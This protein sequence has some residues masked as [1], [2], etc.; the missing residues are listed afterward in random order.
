M[1]KQIF[2]AC[3][4]SGL[5]AAPAQAQWKTNVK[6]IVSEP[7]AV[8]AP[9]KKVA[10]NNDG[11]AYSYP[12]GLKNLGMIS[13]DDNACCNFLSFNKTINGDAYM[14]APIGEIVSYIDASTTAATD[15]HWFIPGSEASE[16]ET[17]DADATYN[18]PGIYEFPTMTIKDENGAEHSYTA[19]GKIKVGGVGE[20]C[21]SN[22]LHLG[23][24]P[25]DPSTSSVVAALMLN[26][27][28][29]GY[30]GG[31]NN[32]KL[33]GYGNLFMIAHPEA[34]ITAVRVYLPDV[35][36]KFA[37]DAKLLMQIWYPMDFGDGEM[38][39][40]GLPLE[41][42][43][44]PMKDIKLT[45]DTKLKKAAVAEFN[46]ETPLT[47]NDKPFF[48]VTISGFGEDP[49]TE[50]FRMLIDIKPTEMDEASAG[51]LLAHNS[52]CYF[53]SG[54]ESTSGY[55]WPINYFG[56]PIGG[57]FMICPVIDT[58]T[59]GTSGINNGTVLKPSKAIYSQGTLTMNCADADEAMVYNVAGN[60]VYRTSLNGA[61]QTAQLQLPEGVYL[62]RYLKSGKVIGASK[63]LANK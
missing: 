61:E 9:V 25:E 26:N 21:T 35:P 40:N 13:T 31:T 46:L 20:I 43:N 63:F 19:E 62:V 42:V 1:K 37:E 49:N 60:I 8:T 47:I 57:S 56:G 2:A 5:L 39:L 29:G 17:Q 44:L 51:N 27:G 11:V 32:M 52:F 24:D 10:R 18:T 34:S 3:V 45:N 30:L 15:Y 16:L 41:A 59:G 53:D 28:A 33:K 48:F 54:N 12:V 50:D 6:A 7:K 4:L 58:K 22:M 55:K 23:T 14:W 36:S 38:V